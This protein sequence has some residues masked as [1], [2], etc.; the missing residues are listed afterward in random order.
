MADIDGLSRFS[1]LKERDVAPFFVGRE[2]N[3]NDIDMAYNDAVESYHHGHCI[4]SETRLF[5]G[6]PGAGKTSLLHEIQARAKRGGFGTPIPHVLRMPHYC[7]NTEKAVVM[8]I[9][10]HLQKDGVFRT[11]SHEQVSIGAQILNI[12]QGSVQKGQTQDPTEAT[13]GQLR[14][15]YSAVENPLPILLCVDEIQNITPDAK[16]MLSALHEGT[17]G[18]PIIP[19]YAGLGNALDTLMAH[20]VSRPVSGYIHSVGALAPEEAQECVQ[21]MFAAFKVKCTGALDDWPAI[22]A[23]WSDCWPQHLHNGMRALAHELARPDVNGVLQRVVLEN[24]ARTARAFRNEAYG[25][26]IS[27]MLSDH[28]EL[29]AHV[30]QHVVTSP[31]TRPAVKQIITTLH[32]T[33]SGTLS[34]GF[35]VS[36]FF[37]ELLHQGLLQEFHEEQPD[38]TMID[39]MRCPIPSLATY[40]MQLGGVDPETVPSSVSNPSPPE[41]DDFGNDGM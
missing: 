28:R 7:L 11:I 3:L 38:G 17:H 18:L 13:F 34:E 35:S 8:E 37:N 9:A 32:Q 23:A 25:W 20:G 36:N 21:D 40:V 24:V 10:E 41:D 14:A 22:L 6:A 4:T 26:R 39:V 1:R 19:I 30:M 31:L 16:S 5:Y 27:E 2:H 33:I 12:L 29:A 15:L